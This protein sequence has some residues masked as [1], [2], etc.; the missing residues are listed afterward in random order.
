MWIH[1]GCQRRYVNFH[2]LPP[3]MQHNSFLGRP[4]DGIPAH[5][6]LQPIVC[7]ACTSFC[8]TFMDAFGFIDT[9]LTDSAICFHPGITLKKR[10]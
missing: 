1:E 5:R 6:E 10:M 8:L 3:A 2:L 4:G 7:L 9:D